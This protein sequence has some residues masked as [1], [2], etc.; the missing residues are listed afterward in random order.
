MLL[1]PN[2][3]CELPRCKAAFFVGY[4]RVL[5]KN[6]CYLSGVPNNMAFVRNHGHENVTRHFVIEIL[7]VIYVK[8]SEKVFVNKF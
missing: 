3:D 8:I 4:R 7:C 5:L 2:L 6:L 1:A